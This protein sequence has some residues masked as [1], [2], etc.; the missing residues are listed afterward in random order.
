ML[1]SKQ[2]PIAQLSS[3]SR[4]EVDGYCSAQS[5]CALLRDLVCVVQ[6]HLEDG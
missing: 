6:V 3:D 2:A 5:L 1:Q 4:A